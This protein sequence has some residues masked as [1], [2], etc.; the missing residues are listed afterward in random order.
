MRSAATRQRVFGLL[1]FL[2]VSAAAG[3]ALIRRVSAQ[4]GAPAEHHSLW[5]HPPEIGRTPETV[6][7]FVERCRR[8]NID[9]VILLV[10]GMNGEI[11]WPSGRFSEAVVKGYE[12]FDMLGELAKA[13]H[14]YGIK[15]HA[16]LVDF[17]EGV[18]SPAVR[19]HP[20]W[21]EL[22]PA[23]G[24]TATETLGPRKRPYPYVWMCPAR[25][26][27]YT[28]QWLLP[29]I[30]ELARNP[31]VDGIHHD[32][33]RYP[34]DV[35]PDSY[36][37]CDYCLAH[38]PRYAMLAY[39]TRPERYDVDVRQERI[40]ANWWTD[41][42]MLPVSYSRQDRR[43]RA[44]FLLNGRTIPG[45]PADVRFFFYDYRIQQIDRFVREVQEL[46][47]KINPKLETSAAVF[48]NPVQSGRFLGQQWHRWGDSVDRFTPMTYR[49][50]FAGSFEDY[51]D[52]LEETTRRQIE[53]IGNRR[54]IDAGI[55]ST[56]LYREELKPFDDMNDALD[57]LRDLPN[58]T[59]AEAARRQLNAAVYVLE[60]ASGDPR[61]A[62]QV[63]MERLVAAHDRLQARLAALAP[64]PA[65]ALAGLIAALQQAAPDKV[66]GAAAAVAVE[67]AKIRADLPPGFCPPEKLIRSIE[68]ARRAKPAGIAI[69]AASSITREKLWPVL[70]KAFAR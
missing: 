40:E 9:T 38:I 10:K 5:V 2:A 19:K 64:E 63:A 23:G 34:G 15:I 45:G 17:A 51:V 62:Q 43:E 31:A 16:W 68:A 39:E 27:G 41:P 60:G 55:A 66:A 36:C 33:V 29:M 52:H 12:S 14:P 30:E 69:F 57:S 49:S 1:I 4:S 53:W 56:Y 20:E 58:G 59:D 46:V 8:A 37:F 7:A 44:D 6:R 70:E 54:P 28:D 13:A 24:T 50:H 11:Y 42:T 32:Y 47:K 61:Q 48:K 26:P 3:G 22:N 65:K 18:N 35:A 25:R 67:L 21:A